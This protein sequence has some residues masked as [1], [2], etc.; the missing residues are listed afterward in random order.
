MLS[1]RLVKRPPVLALGAL[2]AI[3]F[4]TACSDSPSEPT[5]TMS[6]A[7]SQEVAP[8]ILSNYYG[9]I[10]FSATYPDLSWKTPVK[11][12]KADTTVASFTVDPDYGALI[13][14]GVN[15]KLIL[16]PKKICDLQ[17]SGYGPSYWD[18]WC[19]L[20]HDNITFTIKSWTGSNGRPYATVTPDVRFKPYVSYSARIYFYDANL[21]KFSDVVIPWCDKNNVCVDEGA[22]DSFLLTYARKSYGPGYWVYRNLRH[23]SGYNVTAF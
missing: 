16:P 8:A 3:G 13:D 4:A 10:D 22:S 19:D 12:K 20:E 14:F 17:T 7:R 6:P 18:N 15:H 11:S 1:S 9:D 2:L 21:V 23:L 5:A